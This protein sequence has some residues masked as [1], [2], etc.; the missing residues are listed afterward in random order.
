MKDNK[1][2]KKIDTD[3]IEAYVSFFPKKEEK[4]YAQ[5][6]VRAGYCFADPGK[7]FVPHLLEHAI[8]NKLMQ[9]E[10]EFE[11]ISGDAY[12]SF[13]LESKKNDFIADFEKFINSIFEYDFPKESYENEKMALINELV[14]KGIKLENRTYNKLSQIR[15]KTKHYSRDVFDKKNIQ[16]SKISE[17]K[18][19]HQKYFKDKN[20][21]LFL[22]ARELGSEKINKIREIIKNSNILKGEKTVFPEPGDYSKKCYL[23]EKF[24]SP[25]AH[26]TMVWPCPSFIQSTEERVGINTIRDLLVSGYKS[27]L[28]QKLRI[29]SSLVY[30]IYAETIMFGKAA[31]FAIYVA[32]EKND[33]TKTIK[34][35][36]KSIDEIKNAKIDKKLLKKIVD[37]QIDSNRKEWASN[38]RFWWIVGD[39]MDFGRV[40][41]AR[42]IKKIDK[43]IGLAFLSKIANK[44]L[45]HK[46]LNIIEYS[47]D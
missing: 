23:K 28:F 36:K 13:F 35:I 26:L 5:L 46:Y 34:I 38:D 22:G 47:K 40:Y 42:E 16:D 37:D 25:K 10:L 33:I 43:S 44:Y 41:D 32:V 15:Y 45:D 21:K 19:Y 30:D 17:M 39:L 24:D 6:F 3:S 4:I 2:Y 11:A 14:D 31:A 29:K 8:A 27:M 9:N 20:I 18:K 1:Y 12:L 7:K